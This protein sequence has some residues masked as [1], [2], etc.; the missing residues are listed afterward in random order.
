[1]KQPEHNAAPVFLHMLFRSGST[2]LFKVFR[3]SDHGYWCYHEP[4]N[5]FLKHLNGDC[6]KLLEMGSD[7]GRHLRHPI[8]DI[9]YF[10]EFYQIRDI[11]KGLFR[12]SFSYDDF[13]ADV[14]SGLPEDQRRYFSALISSARGRPVL[15]FCRSAGRIGALKQAFGGMHIHLWR[16]PRNQ[17]WSFKINYYFDPAV[18]LIYNARGL[19]PVLAEARRR[20]GMMAFQADDFE[21][22]FEYARTHPLQTISNYFAFYALWLYAYLEGEKYADIT[23]SIDSLSAN[24]PYRDT[25]LKIFAQS[26]IEG[27]DF[28]DCSIPR[29]VFTKD[30]CE[31]FAKIEHQV[32]DLFLMYGCNVH[33]QEEAVAAHEGVLKLHDVLQADP[34]REAARARQMTLRYLDLYGQAEARSQWLEN[35][36]NVACARNEALSEQLRAA[37]AGSTCIKGDLQAQRQLMT[38]AEARSLWLES[39]WNAASARNEAMAEQLR[40][41]EGESSRIKGELQAQRLSLTEAEAK[42]HEIFLTLHSLCIS[43]SWRITAPLRWCGHQ[44]R[45]MRRQGLAMRLKALVKKIDRLEV[46]CGAALMSGCSA[47]DSSQSLSG[48]CPTPAVAQLSPRARRIY[49]DLKAAIEHR[50]KEVL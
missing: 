2:Y 27:L 31:F 8:L 23:I 47:E 42:A 48:R 18:Q 3:R 19:P 15:Q 24:E 44:A 30:E 29:A 37:E 46:I 13:F 41:V 11:L 22:E 20:C 12:E 10:W 28:S 16:E 45:L 5:E 39:E 25:T 21:K 43:R 50:R 40:A 26:G 14:A 6:E 32:R 34:L 36:W 4:E 35:E 38:E 33:N 17:W 9:P 7:T 49:A 1:M